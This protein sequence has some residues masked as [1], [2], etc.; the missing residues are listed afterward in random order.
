MVVPAIV[1]QELWAT[2][3]A[4]D[5]VSTGPSK[6]GDLLPVLLSVVFAVGTAP[7]A[8][9]DGTKEAALDLLDKQNHLIR[10]CRGYI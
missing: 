3:G 8:A 10:R 7:A 1:I 2:L 5:G 4:F 6:F 9:N